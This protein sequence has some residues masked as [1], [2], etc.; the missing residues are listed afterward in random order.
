[1]TEKH[2]SATLTIINSV[3][4]AYLAKHYRLDDSGELVKSPGGELVSGT[5]EVVTVS[6][7]SEFAALLSSLSPAQ[8]LTYGVPERNSVKI[9]TKSQWL[10]MG[11]PADAV[12][13][14]KDAFS[15]PAG[16]G[17]MMNDYDPGADAGVLDREA[18]LASL[19][20]AVPALAG[21]AAL[22]WPSSSSHIT[23]SDTGEDLTGLRGQRLYWIAQ[24]AGDIPRAGE[25]LETYLWAA[26]HGRIEVGAA[27]QL[28]KRTLIDSSVWQANR[29][30][31]AAGAA[32]TA[33][34]EQR[35][36]HPVVL[37]GAP[38]MDTRAVIPDPDPATVAAAERA[39]LEA[40]R[41][42]K[43]EAF[44]VREAYLEERA[45]E[46]AGAD[47][48]DERLE[49]C[50]AVV[51][52]ALDHDTLAGDFPL[53]IDVDGQRLALTVGDVLDDPERYHGCLTLDP[54]EPDYQGGKV[55]GKLYLMGSRPRLYSFAHGGLSFKLTRPPARV[56]LV[57]GRT[58][59]AVEQVLALMRR[60]PDVFDFGGPLVTVNAGQVHPMDE[61]SLKHWLGGTTQFWRL[62][63]TPKGQMVEVLEDPPTAIAKQLLSL[64]ERRRLKRL[65]GV[66]TAPTLRPDGSILNQPGFDELTGLLLEADSDD[67]YPVPAQPTTDEVEQ[68]L[69]RLMLPFSDFPLVGP[70]D[71][72]VL[73]AAL[74]TAA[75]R[76][77]LDTAPAIGFDAPV[78]GSGKTLLAKCI[79]VLSLGTV[80]T[81]WPHTH[82]RDDEEI[83]KRIMTILMT[84][85]RAVIWDNVIGVFDSAALAGALTSRHYSDRIL[86]KT[87]AANVPN[88]A[89]WLLTGNNLTLAG[90]LPRRVLKCR[91]DPEMDRP[92]ARQFDLD[93]EAYCKRHRQQMIADA[94]T[95][96]RA[97]LLSG[98]AP[99]PGS[100]ASF[101]GWDSMVRQPVAW[102][103]R[104]FDLLGEYADPME[105]VDAAQAAD[106]EQ[107]Q[108]DALLSSLSGVFG[109]DPFTSKD[110]KRVLD[111]CADAKRPNSFEAIPGDE[112]QT[113]AETMDEF[114]TG[115]EHTGRSIA[116][117]LQFRADRV[118]NGRRLRKRP[119]RGFRLDRRTSEVREGPKGP[120]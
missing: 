6:S 13:R 48:D 88:K 40:K 28:L 37:D 47:A 87:G 73:L 14:S 65:E 5:A 77:V 51:C 98:A 111:R 57:K 102:I 74:L 52:R 105:A 94:L 81:V 68:A 10:K 49:H 93:P 117:V 22:W 103:S 20:A 79:A 17:V 7:L 84:G 63:R 86:G 64:G 114:R 1:M 16:A 50:R 9:V 115:R 110:V 59:D 97:W 72:G 60:A 39:I 58:V 12:P 83:R 82:A 78:Q 66:I 101:E 109:A 100:M 108:L 15:W 42:A 24:D 85:A 41:E 46:M 80:P 89:I 44:A 34:L 23:R 119:G 92:F 32:C 36:G 43:P 33:P 56:E 29:L 76:P 113:L 2:A 70:V 8:A 27:G 38:V 106:P 11:R 90:D 69:E 54:I 99:A 30:D 116:K 45:I 62:H 3:K 19:Y 31:F 67:L 53:V 112:Q 55:V 96:I 91:I 35:R 104:E 18:L 4:P 21:V 71:R 118:V 25:A 120:F 75:V 107:E 26:G 95:I 61:H